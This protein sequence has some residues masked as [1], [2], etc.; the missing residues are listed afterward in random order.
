MAAGMDLGTTPAMAPHTTPALVTFAAFLQLPA[1]DLEARVAQ[2]LAENPALEEDPEPAACPLCGTL[3]GSPGLCPCLDGTAA[4][5]TRQPGPG[6]EPPAD[7][8][9]A[10]LLAEVGAVLPAEDAPLAAYLLG[11][12]GPRGR[13]DAPVEEIAAALGV[14]PGRARRAL[15]ALRTATPAGT[16]AHDLRECLLLQLDR[17]EE[18]HGARV[19]LARAVLSRHLESLADEDGFA[20]AARALGVPVEEV[21]RVR[22]FVRSELR[23]SAEPDLTPP[24]AAACAPPD[25]VITGDHQGSYTV[26]LL[27]PLR[28]RL[29]VSPSYLA[30]AADSG[31]SGPAGERLAR[32]QVCRARE[33]LARLD[34]RWRTL[35]RIAEYVMDAQRPFLD[36][37]PAGLRP[38]RRREV[39]NALGL[40]ESTVCRAVAGRVALLPCRRTMPLAGFFGAGTDVQTALRDLVAHEARPLSDAE[41]AGLLAEH[42]FPVARRTVAKYRTAL[43]IE[44]RAHRAARPQAA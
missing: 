22:A 34:G 8:R 43:G 35:R 5:A 38:L 13:L 39:A 9:A 33:F 14:T 17:W 20:E 40:H 37:G 12:L 10:W 16:G 31:G 41:L 3:F 26:T 11:S 2:E 21:R 23:P 29:A 30:F 42:G 19:P 24:P 27:E 32:A 18:R 15:A 7:E 1:L 28:L 36:E 4:R 6:P 25:L 44:P